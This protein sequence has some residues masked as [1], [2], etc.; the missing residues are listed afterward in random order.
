VR[1]RRAGSSANG[2]KTNVLIGAS[3]YRGVAGLF[4]ASPRRSGRVGELESGRVGIPLLT[5]S[6][7]L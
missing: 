5:D 4:D 3:V 6:L 7:T 1:R 2:S